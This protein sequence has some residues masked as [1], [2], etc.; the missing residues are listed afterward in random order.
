MQNNDKINSIVNLMSE[1]IDIGDNGVTILKNS[2]SLL[3]MSSPTVLAEVHARIDRVISASDDLA[4][5]ILMLNREKKSS[6]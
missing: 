2:V 1:I 3:H 4:W 5:I 6:L